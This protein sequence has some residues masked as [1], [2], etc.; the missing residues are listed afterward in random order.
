MNHMSRNNIMGKGS[1]GCLHRCSMVFWRVLLRLQGGHAAR[2]STDPVIT[3]LIAASASSIVV[4]T[5][6]Q[7]HYGFIEFD[8]DSPIFVRHHGFVF[9]AAIRVG[10]HRHLT[11]VSRYVGGGLSD[12]QT[13]IIRD[14]LT[15]KSSWE[16][17]YK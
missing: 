7:R 11:K 15:M 17:R 9:H 3:I 2:S 1:M 13:D 5:W 12:L 16:Y 14:L 8:A 10:T 6:T 4:P